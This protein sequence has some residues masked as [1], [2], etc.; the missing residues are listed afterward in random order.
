[1]IQ[2]Q[3]YV[4]CA[5]SQLKAELVSS[6]LL[7]KPI[8]LFRDSNGNPR[9]LLD[10]C[11]H[12]GFPLSKSK[13]VDGVI[14]CGFHG[15][16]YN[17][18]GEVI[19]VPSQKDDKPV[20]K[21]FCVPSFPCE[22]K[23]GYVWVWA[24]D[25]KPHAA[26]DMPEIH[27]GHWMQGTRVIECNY[28]RALEITFDAP[29]VYFLHPSHP[30]TIA[31]AKHGIGES[32][33]EL[34]ITDKGCILFGPPAASEADPIPSF[35]FTMEYILPGHIRFALNGNPYMNF[36]TMPM[37][38]NRCR[39]DWTITDWSPKEGSERIRWAG[40]GG[41]VIEEDQFA[42]EL[43][44]RTYEREGESFERSVESDAPTLFLRK[45]VKAAEEGPLL[46]RNCGS[47]RR[48]VTMMGATRYE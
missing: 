12:R 10:R 26:P 29:H 38:Q 23:D 21:S 3:W 8:V 7:D 19:R 20:P 39:M 9:A 34:R 48:L 28:L 24:G 35:G 46:E 15:W 44:Q 18:L 22:E 11:C 13:L 5:S 2:N 27:T 17:S 4:G 25:A 43:I 36:F 1:M 33:L 37:G 16:K 42:L 40:E 6:H 45:I 32:Q 30:A 14:Q 31:A 47:K 41:A